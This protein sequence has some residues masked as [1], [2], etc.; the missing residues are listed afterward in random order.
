[1]IKGPGIGRV[2]GAVLGMVMVC[3]LLA[4][5]AG[6]AEKVVIKFPTVH[7]DPK[8]LF[9]QGGSK[10]GEYLMKKFPGRVE[11]QLYPASQLGNEREIL[12]GLRIGT[13]EMTTSGVAG[14]ADPIYDVFD[15]PFL[16]RDRNHVYSVLD[17]EVGKELLEKCKDSKLVAL[18]Y[19]ENGWRHITNNKRPINSPNDLRGLK[20]RV[21][22]HRI[23]MATMKTLGATAVPIPYGE[24]YTALKT[25][26]VDGQDNPLVNIFTAKFFE[27]Q[28]YLT[29]SGH[30]YSNNVVFAS[31]AWFDKLPAD[32][33][34]G[35]REAVAEAMVLV[36]TESIKFDKEL[37]GKLQSGGMVV[38]EIKDKT[39]FVEGTKAVYDQFATVFPP[40]LV[41]RIRETP[42]KS[43]PYVQ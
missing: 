31:K 43:Y 16:F 30:V 9:N 32:L 2:V 21:V 12:E 27:V 20:Q 35:I 26:V 33:Q 5:V 6:A 11:F 14:L 15:M 13:I 19:F 25:G 28:K 1:M 24:L 10:V 41:R 22:E 8:S 18:G 29:L 42:S 23:Y 39:P 40:E 17:G 4:G 7:G 3:A 37:V 36:R 34:A 38:N